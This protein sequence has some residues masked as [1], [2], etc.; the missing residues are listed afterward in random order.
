MMGTSGAKAPHQTKQR[1]AALKR[2]ATQKLSCATQEL[3]CATQELSFATQKLSSA[4][5]N[6][7]FS[8][9]TLGSATARPGCNDP[10]LHA[11]VESHPSQRT[12]RMG[13]PATQILFAVQILLAVAILSSLFV[14]GQNPAT[15]IADSKSKAD[16][17]F[18]H[19]MC[20]RVCL[21]LRSSVPSCA[22][23]QL[24]CGATAFRPWGRM[25]RS[26]S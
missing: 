18:I 15:A 8:T 1:F 19:A 26:R 9:Q 7:S 25:R 22:R 17:I 4:T 16:V 11:V 23:R 14:Q 20:T 21:R 10:M 24:R 12:R 3:S 5:Q 2:C 13:H 6:L